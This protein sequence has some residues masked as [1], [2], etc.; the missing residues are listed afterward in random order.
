M[1]L[2]VKICGITT[3]EA[4]AAAAHAG[5]DFVGLNFHPTS[6]RHV[7][8]DQAKALAERLRP[9]LRIVVLLVDPSDEQVA[10][11]VEAAHPDFLQ[12]HG[13]ETP[14]RTHQIRARFGI[15]VI[16]AI[17]VA[18]ASDLAKVGWYEQAADRLLFDTKAPQGATYPGGTGAAFDWQLLRGRTFRQR[19]L[20]AGGLNADNVA[21]A[22]EISGAPAVDVSSGVETAPGVKSPD[23]I[24]DFVA[25]ARGAQF[26]A[27]A[28]A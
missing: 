25:A 20:L 27:G 21:R 3:M 15:P 8:P 18:D 26:A 14:E 7:A 16:K 12:L 28:G 1:A 17:A 6:P 22:I 11:A 4:G 10:A 19:W 13:S 9:V 23:L 24:R 2:Q 5:A